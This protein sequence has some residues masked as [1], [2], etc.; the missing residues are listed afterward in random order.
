[1][2]ACCL[3]YFGQFCPHTIR[4][5]IDS[6]YPSHQVTQ[7]YLSDQTLINLQQKSSTLL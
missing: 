1:M 2:L 7:D 4:Q 6:H 3:A 5:L